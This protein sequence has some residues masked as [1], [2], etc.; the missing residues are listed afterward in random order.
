MAAAM[1]DAPEVTITAAALTDLGSCDSNRV[2]IVLPTGVSTITIQDFGSGDGSTHV[3]KRVKLAAGI[4]IKHNPPHMNM[5]FTGG[6][7]LTNIG[8]WAVYHADGSGNWHEEEYYNFQFVQKFLTSQTNSAIMP[9]GYSRARFQLVSQAAATMGFGGTT[10]VLGAGQT[11]YYCEKLFNGCQAGGRFTVTIDTSSTPYCGIA[12]GY[13]PGGFVFPGTTFGGANNAFP[14]QN[15]L[16]AGGQGNAGGDIMDG[17][18]S[19]TYVA[20]VRAYTPGI[21]RQ[22][23]ITLLPMTPPQEILAGVGPQFL[24][25]LPDGGAGIALNGTGA[26]SANFKPGP[27][28]VYITWLR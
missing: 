24:S 8:D 20:G 26:T 23:P 9:Y 16:V 11:G 10:P 27:P 2:K 6:D 1:G 13:Q 4:T 17:A 5:D 22:N 25:G 7:R 18:I 21:T 19:G 14:Q 28:A 12:S 3:T 15:Y